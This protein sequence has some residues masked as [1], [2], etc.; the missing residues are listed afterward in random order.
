M[1]LQR[2]VYSTVNSK[3]N[4][5]LLFEKMLFHFFPLHTHFFHDGI[6]TFMLSVFFL[7]NGVNAILYLQQVQPDEWTCGKESILY[8]QCTKADRC[9]TLSFIRIRRAQKIFLPFF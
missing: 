5:K 1:F 3:N 4:L 2:T 8:L 9:T 6:V 7:I